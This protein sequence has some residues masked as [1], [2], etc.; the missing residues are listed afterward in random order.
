MQDIGGCRVVLPTADDAFIFGAE[1]VSSRIRHKLVRYHNYISKPRSTGYRGLHLMYEYDSD[2][3][4][5]WEGLQIE[6]QLLFQFQH[7]WATAV[8]NRGSF[9]WQRPQVQPGPSDMAPV[10]RSNE[11][12][13]RPP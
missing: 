12:R 11:L 9:R 8:G 7:Q 1:F 5:G 4:T 10:F 2:R 6:I 3:A 13:D